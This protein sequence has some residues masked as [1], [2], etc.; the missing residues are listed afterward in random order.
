MRTCPC[1]LASFPHTKSR[2]EK[3]LLAITLSHM[4]MPLGTSSP[5]TAAQI[6]CICV[7]MRVVLALR[8]PSHLRIMATLPNFAHNLSVNGPSGGVKGVGLRAFALDGAS[9]IASLQEL[10]TG[11]SVAGGAWGPEAG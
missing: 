8:T 5:P 7:R 6:I 1:L 10:R 11:G 4:H 9:E 2:A 3:A